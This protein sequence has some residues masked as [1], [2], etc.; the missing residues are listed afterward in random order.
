MPTS[1]Y[2]LLHYLVQCNG[3]ESVDGQRNSELSIGFLFIGLGRIVLSSGLLVRMRQILFACVGNSGLALM[4]VRHLEIRL[5][6]AK[7]CK[8][9]QSSM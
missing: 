2:V 9:G 8:I 5:V 3:V 6:A 1:V 7:C 4:L